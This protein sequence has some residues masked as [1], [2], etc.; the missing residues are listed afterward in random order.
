MNNDTIVYAPQCPRCG[1]FIPSNQRPGEYM[2]A[3][4]RADNHTYVCSA[5]GTEEAMEDFIGRSLTT[6]DQWPVSNP[7]FDDPAFDGAIMRR[8]EAEA[9]VQTGKVRFAET[10]RTVERRAVA[11]DDNIDGKRYERII[12]QEKNQ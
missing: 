3:L 10:A 12:A 2:G 1:G 11:V 4:S 7:A 9:I 6:P 5:C 8:I